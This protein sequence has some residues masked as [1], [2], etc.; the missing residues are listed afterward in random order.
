MKPETP[1]LNP[2]RKSLKEEAKG[3]NLLSEDELVERIATLKES[4]TA[5]R[6]ERQEL[7]RQLRN[8]KFECLQVKGV[9][10]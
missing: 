9:E 2:R 7:E 3:E 8:M 10:G 6:I 1:E 4:E 5:L